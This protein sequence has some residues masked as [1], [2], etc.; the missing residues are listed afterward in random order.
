MITTEPIR[1]GSSTV[2]WTALTPNV[3]PEPPVAP[4][5]RSWR[6]R[7]WLSICSFILTSSWR[8]VLVRSCGESDYCTLIYWPRQGSTRQKFQSA[9]GGCRQESGS[10]HVS[11]HSHLLARMNER[12][13]VKFES[14]TDSNAAS[15]L[16]AGL[17]NSDRAPH[18]SRC[19]PA[20]GVIG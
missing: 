4:I 8:T 10:V 15:I 16:D 13:C 9:S 20:V 12:N 7:V 11:P 19:I 14:S 5:R 1:H 2:S 17:Q 6:R 3:S 18:F